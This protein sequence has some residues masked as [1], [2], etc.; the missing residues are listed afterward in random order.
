MASKKMMRDLWYARVAIAGN[1][2][3]R[4]L[5]MSRYASTETWLTVSMFLRFYWRDFDF[6]SALI[7][8]ANRGKRS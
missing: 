6:L 8:N 4:A 7:D 3:G 5:L 1:N 2:A